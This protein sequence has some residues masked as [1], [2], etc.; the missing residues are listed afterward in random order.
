MKAPRA[1]VA[2]LGQRRSVEVAVPQ[3]FAGSNP[4]PRIFSARSAGGR[5]I[6]PTSQPRASAIRIASVTTADSNSP[7]RALESAF[8]TLIRSTAWISSGSGRRSVGWHSFAKKRGSVPSRWAVKLFPAYISRNFGPWYPVSSRSS[9]RAHASGDS[10][11]LAVPPGSDWTIRPSPCRYSRVRTIC[12]CG[13][14]ART[15]AEVP[16]CIRIHR[17]RAPLGS[18]TSSSEIGGHPSRKGWDDRM[19]GSDVMGTRAAPRPGY[20][21][22]S[23]HRRSGS[24]SSEHNSYY[25]PPGFPRPMP[26]RFWKKDKPEKGKPEKETAEPREKPKEPP[27]AKPA[28]TEKAAKPAEKPAA[29]AAPP[30]PGEVEVFVTEAHAGLVDLGLTVAPTKAVFAKRVA[31]YPGGDA[32]FVAEYRSAPY[33]AVTRVLAD[34]LG[35]RVPETFE[36]GAILKHVNPRLSSFKLALA[37]KDLTWLDQELNL[38]KVKLI[39]GDQEKVVRFKDAR[40]L[41]KGVNEILASRKLAFVELETWADDFAFLLVRDPRWDKLKNPELVVIKADQ[42]ATGGECGECGAPVGK[43]WSDCLKCGAVFG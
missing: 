6:H 19:R 39:L 7:P 31:A 11:F 21:S 29:P 17:F 1:W 34:W 22:P 12:F 36:L 2:Q 42:T 8:V 35:F 27:A 9:R 26:L 13:V 18:S 40:D 28:P 16:K 24:R 25:E 4:A 30:K 32:A 5:L 33:K 10:P 20:L 15:A 37:A 14:T 38:R 41:L 23:M 3:G 43:Y